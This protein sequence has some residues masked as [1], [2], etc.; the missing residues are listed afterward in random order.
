MT[1][2]IKFFNLLGI[3]IA[4]S[5]AGKMNME[6]IRHNL[7]G[8][9]SLASQLREKSPEILNIWEE[10]VRKDHS[11]LANIDSLSLKNSLQEVIQN[12]ADILDHKAK[13]VESSLL[14]D[15]G[16][17]RANF[18]DYTI[19][20]MIS[21]YN[22]LRKAIFYCLR[23]ENFS[24][25]EKEIIT[26]TIEEGIAQAALGFA[27]RQFEMREHFIATLAHDLRNPLSAAKTSAQLINKMNDKPEKVKDL[28]MKI[29]ETI[30]RAD[31]LISDLLDSNLVRLGKEFSLVVSNT[32]IRKIIQ[33][34]VDEVSAIH[35]NRFDYFGPSELRGF[36]DSSLLQ[37]TISNLLT[38]AVKYGDANKK[39]TI[40]AYQEN[41]LIYVSVHNFGE[42]IS[43]EVEKHIFD[44]FY[45]KNDDQKSH[46]KSWGIGLYL[47]NGAVKAHGGSISLVSN[48]LDG[49]T[50]TICIPKD[51]RT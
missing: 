4:K 30:D 18:P 39:I 17:Y 26:E 28:S 5:F 37:R 34:S 6:Q 51:C 9:K 21:E 31:H 13:A 46:E 16:I 35:G 41:N 10:W 50:F 32:D 15:H 19:D 42:S 3:I 48:Q 25:K 14:R 36:W 44:R 12:L 27:K 43:S 45:Q 33:E 1:A 23:V 11:I 24:E 2:L 22:Y 38:N 7:K 29:V 8:N 49:T 47:V 40:K 20:K